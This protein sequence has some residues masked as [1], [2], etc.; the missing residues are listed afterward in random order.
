MHHC[1]FPSGGKRRT[2]HGRWS[3]SAKPALV[4]VNSSLARN[5]SPI[6]GAARHSQ[7]LPGTGF[8]AVTFQDIDVK[9]DDGFATFFMRG[10][11]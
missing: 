3:P 2:P 1:V 7:A 8:S 5:K 10:C 6:G 4:V 11:V 9:V